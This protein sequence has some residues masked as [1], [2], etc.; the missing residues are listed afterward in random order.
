MDTLWQIYL[1][2]LQLLF[3]EITTF[4]GCLLTT[5]GNLRLVELLFLAL[6]GLW[7]LSGC[8]VVWTFVKT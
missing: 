7:G 6:A 5:E 2:V 8:L 4:T 3:C 1:F